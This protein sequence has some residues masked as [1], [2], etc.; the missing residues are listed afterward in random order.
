MRRAFSS[1][2]LALTLAAPVAV[3]A[4]TAPAELPDSLA[5]LTNGYFNAIQRNDATTLADAISNTF[6]QISPDGKRISF[7]AFMREVGSLYFIAQA[8]MGTTVKIR[9]T[10]ITPTGATESVDTLSWYYGGS[11][12][13]PMSGPT[14]VRTFST[15]RLTWIKSS[16]GKWLL[17]EDH[18]TSNQTG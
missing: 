17:D 14:E 4:Q 18:V 1:I 2:V 13:D 15:H 8:P 16:T 3:A 9:A 7:E 12:E 5:S 6:H 10:T 11:P